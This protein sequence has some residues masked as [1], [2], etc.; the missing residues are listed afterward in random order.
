MKQCYDFMGCSFQLAARDL[1]HAQFHKQDNTYD[2]LCYHMICGTQAAMRNISM[3]LPRGFD[4]TTHHTISRHSTTQLHATPTWFVE[5]RLEW[6]ISQWVCQ[7]GSIQQPITPLA[8]IL[9]QSYMPLPHVL[10]ST[11][12]N[13]KYLNESATRV[14]SDNPLLL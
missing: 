8:D 14:R 1:L 11:G 2:G 6:E 10:W 12:R 13:E 9:P 7:E 3:G 5:H 4:P